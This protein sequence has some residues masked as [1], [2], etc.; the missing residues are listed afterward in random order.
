MA[1]GSRDLGK[2]LDEASG[3]WFGGGNWW[4]CGRGLEGRG[5]GFQ[6]A[7]FDF[8]REHRN[9]AANSTRAEGFKGMG[10][11]ANVVV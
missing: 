8:W 2:V 11:V 9:A 3:G 5:L 6:C 4:S 10:S 1:R 7:S